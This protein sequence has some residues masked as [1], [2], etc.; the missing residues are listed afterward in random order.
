VVCDAKRAVLEVPRPV[1][2]P[3]NVEALVDELL[4]KCKELQVKYVQMKDVLE[5]MEMIFNQS[6][7]RLD[8]QFGSMAAHQKRNSGA[9]FEMRGVVQAIVAEVGEEAV[10]ARMVSVQQQQGGRQ[11]DYFGREFHHGHAPPPAHQ[12]GPGRSRGDFHASYPDNNDQWR[13]S[14]GGR[15]GGRR[16]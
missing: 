6:V 16:F 2:P 3:R 13:R 4:E 8:D 15:G 10:N 5:R 9:I 11:A 1:T 12:H 14:R 7:G